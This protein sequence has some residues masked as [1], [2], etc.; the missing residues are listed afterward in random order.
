MILNIITRTKGR[1]KF[2][3]ICYETIHNL[4]F[5]KLKL[6]HWVIYD[7]DD[8]LEY[9]N[10]YKDIK[11]FKA[12]PCQQKMPAHGKL[13]HN[14][15]FNQVYQSIQEGVIFH[16]D[17]DDFI[18]HPNAF[19]DI[20][21][22]ILELKQDEVI[23]VQFEFAY[24]NTG[25]R[26]SLTSIKNEKIV[27]GEVGSSCIICPIQLAK[28]NTWPAIRCGDFHF[29]K[30]LCNKARSIHW[31]KHKIVNAFVPGL[32]LSKDLAESKWLTHPDIKKH[33]LN[34]ITLPDL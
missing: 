3:Q 5:K 25:P 14:D 20:E 29:I 15:Y 9:L 34:K 17:D 2:F 1:P 26:P 6:N 33:W 23:I 18:S 7:D 12:G 16:V 11:L 10:N 19:L 24:N 22:K 13:A 27:L 4:N 28:Q 32:G 8:T 21:D 30:A 31:L